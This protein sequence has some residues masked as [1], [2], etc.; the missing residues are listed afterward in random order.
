MIAKFILYIKLRYYLILDW[1]EDDVR[2]DT[3]VMPI[4]QS[5]QNIKLIR[6]VKKL[7]AKLRSMSV[8]DRMAT[9]NLLGK[10]VYK[11]TKQEILEELKVRHKVLAN[12]ILTTEDDLVNKVVKNHKAYAKEAEIK[13]IRKAITACIRAAGKDPTNPIYTEEARRLKSRSTA[14]RVEIARIKNG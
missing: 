7:V 10:E 5:R 1:F 6:G 8:E 9:E 11:K 4:E 14:L 12:P 13:E 3:D 2:I